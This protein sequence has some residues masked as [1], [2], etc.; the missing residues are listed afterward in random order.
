MVTRLHCQCVVLWGE[1][2]TASVSSEPNLSGSF[3]SF[4]ETIYW[5]QSRL[6]LFVATFT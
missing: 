4:W 6:A 5:G 1:T 2:I 3:L